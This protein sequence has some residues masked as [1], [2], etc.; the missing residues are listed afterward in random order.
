V[1]RGGVGREEALQD[2]VAAPIG[3]L[4]RDAI[5]QD[6]RRVGRDDVSAAGAGLRNRIVPEK[7]L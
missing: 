4:R 7:A 6:G 5:Q 2:I 1:A 3:D